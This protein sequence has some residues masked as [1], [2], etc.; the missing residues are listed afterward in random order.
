MISENRLVI[1]HE[2]GTD[3]VLW[4]RMPPMA[5][6]GVLMTTKGK[7]TAA[8]GFVVTLAVIALLRSLPPDQRAL[9]ASSR[10]V[11]ALGPCLAL[12]SA[13]GMIAAS[14]FGCT[15]LAFTLLAVAVDAKT[16]WRRLAGYVLVVAL[17]VIL[18]ILGVA[19]YV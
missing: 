3:G 10:A 5:N 1:P 4:R 17:W 14:L 2:V 13:N 6:D 11:V 16:M 19:P 9:V 12:A 7:R 15:V 8:I 18:G